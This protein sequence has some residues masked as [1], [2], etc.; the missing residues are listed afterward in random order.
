VRS[1]N[2]RWRF[3]RETASPLGYVADGHEL[4]ARGRLQ[5]VD[6]VRRVLRVA[7]R[8]EDR[9]VVCGEHAQPVGDVGGV[10]L[11]R[12]KRQIE[13]G[14]EERCAELGLCGI[15]HKLNYAEWRIMPHARCAALGDAPA[16]SA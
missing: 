12:L 3:G 2:C 9:A 13:I 15:P 4:T 14:T 1:C 5:T 10:V 7:G 6:E 11:A 8:R 16:R